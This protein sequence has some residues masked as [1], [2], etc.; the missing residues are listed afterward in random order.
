MQ[1]NATLF[2]VKKSLK[3]KNMAYY[4]LVYW[5]LRVGYGY[6]IKKHLFAIIFVH[7]KCVAKNQG[8]WQVF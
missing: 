7:Y 3:N 6:L 5:Y 4:L 8:T 1:R 2:H